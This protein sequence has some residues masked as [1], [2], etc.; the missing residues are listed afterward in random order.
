M[1]RTTEA[2]LQGAEQAPRSQYGA[3]CWRMHRGHVEVLLI[4]SRDTGRWVIPKGWPI[5]G[6]AP[7]ASAAREAWEEAG[8]H[9]EPDPEAL[10]LYTYDKVLNPDASLPCAVVVF[11]LRV[12]ELAAKFPERKERRRKWFAAAKAAKKVAEPELRNL[13]KTLAEDPS[14]L[15]GAA[16]APA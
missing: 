12:E 16:V 4:T 14:L 3:I 8:V 10:G 11:P 15:S 7:A 2:S 1:K 6:L 9:G 13:F 5:D